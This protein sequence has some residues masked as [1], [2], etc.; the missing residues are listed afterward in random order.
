M[1]FVFLFPVPSQPKFLQIDLYGVL[2]FFEIV[3]DAE[4]FND[5]FDESDDDGDVGV[6]FDDTCI[7]EVGDGGFNFNEAVDDGF[8]VNGTG[9]NDGIGV[10]VIE[11]GVGDGFGV[12]GTGKNDGIG[13]IVIEEGAGNGFGED[14]GSSGDCWFIG[15][16]INIEDSCP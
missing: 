4:D 7:I 11:E 15:G 3:F 1:Q 2:S 9:K 14:G 8:V 16:G 10:I 13:V 6:D 12:N 5:C